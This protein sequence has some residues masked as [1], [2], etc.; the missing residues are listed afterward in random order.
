[1]ES[2]SFLLNNKVYK[3][4]I[5]R[6]KRNNFKFYLIIKKG[7]LIASVPYFVTNKMIKEFIEEHIKDCVNY[8]ENKT[9]LFSIKEKFIFLRR[10]KYQLLISTG[11]KKNSYEISDNCVYL[12]TK[13]NTKFEIEK[14]I[15][16]I[17]KAITLKYVFKKLS[18]FEQKM[19]L[20]KH[21]FSVSYRKSFWGKNYI[22]K[23]KISFN[24]KLSHFKEEITDYIIIHELCHDKV[25]NHSKD[26]WKIVEK[27]KPNFEEM[28][29]KLKKI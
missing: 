3:V 12:E 22:S 24:S 25:P 18:F 17:L 29:E 16:E 4:S 9:S 5:K 15:K 27:Y 14:I 11:F 2:M 26:F 10:K 13:N 7:K 21:D 19:N 1:M 23:N 20:K 28:N 6:A 8:L